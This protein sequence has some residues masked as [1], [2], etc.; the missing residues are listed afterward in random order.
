MRQQTLA[1]EG[2]ETNRKP[3]RREQFLNEMDR[4]IPWAELSAVIEPAYPKVGGRGRPPVGVERML[5]IHFLQHWF[6]LSDPAV[7][8]VHQVQSPDHGRASVP[9]PQMHLQLQQGP[10]LGAGQERQLAVRGLRVGQFVDG[11]TTFVA[12]N[13]GSV[14]P[15]SAYG[16]EFLR[17]RHNSGPHGAR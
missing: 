15:K 1:E 16:P 5:R 10:L 9:D 7:E 17:N 4:V 13:I 8:E 14:C 2:F 6:K 11:A 3:N 12:N